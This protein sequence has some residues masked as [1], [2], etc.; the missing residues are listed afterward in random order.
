MISLL[1]FTTHAQ[2]PLIIE[3]EWPWPLLFCTM[4]TCGC[5]QGY[6]SSTAIPWP[7]NLH[8]HGHLS[9]HLS[10]FQL[11]LP[12]IGWLKSPDLLLILAACPSC[13][14]HLFLWQLT[15]TIYHRPLICYRHLLIEAQT[16]EKSMLYVCEINKTP[17]N[18]YAA[19]LFWPSRQILISQ[20]VVR[21]NCWQLFTLSTKLHISFQMSFLALSGFKASLTYGRL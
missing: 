7:I 9:I 3:T 2:L 11:P 8:T 17:L 5:E 21:Y 20:H 1:W 15:F 4:C 16:E 10:F 14:P 13:L 6:Q 19:F 12:G 18:I